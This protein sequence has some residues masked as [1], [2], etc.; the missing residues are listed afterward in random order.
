MSPNDS[1]VWAYDNVEAI[2]PWVHGQPNGLDLQQY[3]AGVVVKAKHTLEFMDEHCLDN[4][5]A[6]C[7]VPSTLKFKLRGKLPKKLGVGRDFS[8]QASDDTGQE[9]DSFQG[10]T[11]HKIERMDNQWALVQVQDST[12]KVLAILH[13][14]NV[15]GLKKWT[16]NNTKYAMKFSQVSFSLHS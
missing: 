4:Y 2:F 7:Q 5:Y 11:N 8:S 16:Y 13:K 6:L 1:W 3:L 15:L 9:C 10:Y 14:N 12:D